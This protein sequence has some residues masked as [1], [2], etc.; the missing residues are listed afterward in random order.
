MFMYYWIYDSS[1]KMSKQ[2]VELIDSIIKPIEFNG[3]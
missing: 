1:L 2:E 3:L